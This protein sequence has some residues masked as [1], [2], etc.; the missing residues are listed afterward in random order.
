[1]GNMDY[2]RRQNISQVRRQF[3]TS[4]DWDF[5][6]DWKGYAFYHP[7]MSLLQ[8]QIKSISGVNPTL[9]TSIIET[10]VRGYR[11]QQAGWTTSDKPAPI[12]LNFVDYEDQSLKY[13]FLEWQN[14]MDSLTT[15]ASY[16]R[17]Q[18]M[19]DLYVWRLN[20]NRQKVWEMHYINCLPNGTTYTDNYEGD[21]KQ[22]VGGDINIQLQAEIAIPTP[23]T[24]PLA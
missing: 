13:W 23:L 21:N 19:V 9:E 8:T 5:L 14:K 12:T 2:I 4:Y 15:H 18:L 17:E 3:L 1:M 10:S 20:S 7:D 16:R 11:V 22:I 24:T 6:I